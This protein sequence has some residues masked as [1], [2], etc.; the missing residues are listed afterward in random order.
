[1]NKFTPIALIATAIVLAGVPAAVFAAETSQSVRAATEATAP[2]VSV[3]A[4]KMIYGANG[5]RI[6]AVYRVTAAGAVQVILDG[7][8][9]TVPA[10]S[11]S[12]ANGKVTTTLTK[13]EL[14]HQ[15]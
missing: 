12:E 1:M 2:A 5:Q 14:A 4:G 15:R 6:A 9:V 8:L 13:S 3:T 11:L 7:K 10:S